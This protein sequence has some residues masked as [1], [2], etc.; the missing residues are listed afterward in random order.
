MYGWLDG[1]VQKK[2]A[3]FKVHCMSVFCLGRG[4]KRRVVLP[5]LRTGS[6]LEQLSY[7]KIM[8]LILGKQMRSQLLGNVCHVGFYTVYNVWVCGLRWRRLPA[9]K[10]PM[11]CTRVNVPDAG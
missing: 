1:L 3:S 6:T 10:D 11:S 9:A 8:N 7:L 2:M 5:I 4:L